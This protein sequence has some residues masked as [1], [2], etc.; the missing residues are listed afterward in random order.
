MPRNASQV[1]LRTE[2]FAPCAEPIAAQHLQA[3]R[4]RGPAM[5]HHGKKRPRA[6]VTVEYAVLLSP[7]A[8][9]HG[10]HDT[11]APLRGGLEQKGAANE[12]ITRGRESHIHGIVHPG[13]ENHVCPRRPRPDVCSSATTTRPSLGTGDGEL[14]T[15]D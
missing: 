11:V 2:Q 9:M 6:W 15:G 10:V 8:A 4:G 14:G 13:G 1:E 7:H 12:Q 3:A 5:D